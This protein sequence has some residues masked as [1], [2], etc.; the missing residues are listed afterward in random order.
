MVFLNLLIYIASFVAIWLGAGVIISAATKFSKKLKLS[1]FVFSFAF[2][3]ILTSTPEFSIGL[4]AVADHDAEIFVGN[5]LGGIVVLFL[6]VIPILAVF[7]NGVSLKHELGNKTLLTTLLVILLPSLFTMDKRITNLEGVIMIASYLALL[8]LVQI[9]N[10]IFDTQNKQI[11]NIRA[12]SYKDLLKIIIGLGIVFV[13]SSL[14]VDK[15]MYFANLLHI[16]AFYISLIVIALGTDLP[17]L[18]M[19]IRSVV[20][21]KKELAMG[22][23]VGAAAVSTF[24]FG[25]FTILHNG[26]VI[27]VNNFFVTFIFITIALGLFYFFS[28]T[29]NYITRLNGLILL[30]IYVLF[31]AL[32]LIK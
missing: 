6:V 16:S 25:L 10:G 11:L 12:Y 7:G 4:Q 2:L 32:E 23:Y 19:A 3:G 29:K 28:Y 17:E 15:T 26:E 5:L 22:D 18:T 30:G 21:G 27:T 20:S 24:L 8:Y 13:S 14:I 31:V 9:K 1:P